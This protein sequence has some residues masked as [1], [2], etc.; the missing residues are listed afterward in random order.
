MAS[1]PLDRPPDA[2]NEGMVTKGVV[3]EGRP[4]AGP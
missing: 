3:T 1:A 4:H 2:L